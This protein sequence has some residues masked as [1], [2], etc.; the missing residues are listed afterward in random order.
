VEIHRSVRRLFR[1]RLCYTCSDWSWSKYEILHWQWGRTPWVENAIAEH[2]LA[3][4]WAWT[5]GK[6]KIVAAWIMVNPAPASN[7][8][9]SAGWK[10]L[11]E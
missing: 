1:E 2:A 6:V 4:D 9:P 8:R 5:R 3:Y 7:S 11:E 10:P